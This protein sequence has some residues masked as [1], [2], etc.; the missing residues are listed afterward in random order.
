MSDLLFVGCH[1]YLADGDPLQLLKALRELGQLDATCFVPGHGPIGTLDDLR[2]LI[3][4][5]E[6]CIET[7]QMLVEEG[8]ANEATITKLKIA[9]KYQHW[10]LS[11][12][13]PSNIHFLCERLSS[14]NGDVQVY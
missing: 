13:Y 4:Y 6:H 12:F 7:A 9:E 8:S 11:Q 14:A 3:E 1:P 2:I 5:I 10:Q